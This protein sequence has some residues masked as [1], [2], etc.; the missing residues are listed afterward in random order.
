MT[1]LSRSVCRCSPGPFGYAGAFGYWTEAAN[2]PTQV[3]HRWYDPTTGRFLSRDPAKSGRN[4]YVY[5]DNGPLQSADPSGLVKITAYWY[6]VKGTEGYHLG[7]EVEDNVP[8]SPTYGKKWRYNGG[9][10]SYGT[11]NQGALQSKSGPKDDETLQDSKHEI[12]S[13]VV[14]VDDQSPVGPWLKRFNQI[15]DELAQGYVGYGVLGVNSNSWAYKLLKEAGLL[16]E[17]EKAL[18]KRRRAGH[19]DKWLP[20][21]GRDPWGPVPPERGRI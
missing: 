21:Y 18:K 11:L 9:P 17:F 7:I 13:G 19:P 8:G 16:D 12:T 20:G 15:E 2:R 5:C 6:P 10:E 1:H 3:G 4:W 14:L